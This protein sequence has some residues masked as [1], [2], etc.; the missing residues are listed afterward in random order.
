MTDDESLVAKLQQAGLEVLPPVER[1]C[2]IVPELQTHAALLHDFRVDEIDVLCAHML[3]VHAE[4]GQTLIAEGD[5]GSW[6][7]LIFSGTVD[8]TK[9]SPRN[10]EASRL[11]VIKRGAAL[12]EMSMLDGEPRYA[13]CIA[14]EPVVAGV[15]TRSTVARL[16]SEQPAVGAKL[17]VKLTQLLAQRLRNTSNQLVKALAARGTDESVSGV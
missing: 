12:G 14:I 3:R 11:A 9:R 5:T 7:L 16:I 13:S 4:P 8:V 2:E 15:L 1:I 10:G 6:M 17:L